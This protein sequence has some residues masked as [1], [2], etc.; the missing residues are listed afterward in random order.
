[1]TEQT[2]VCSL[3]VVQGAYLLA[4]ESKSSKHCSLSHGWIILTEVGGDEHLL[5]ASV[6]P[7]PIQTSV[8]PRDIPFPSG[9]SLLSDND[10]KGHMTEKGNLKAIW[11]T[12]CVCV[13]LLR[14]GLGFTDDEYR[15][16][17]QRNSQKQEHL[18]LHGGRK[19]PR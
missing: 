4:P 6:V 8:P 18:R 1:V 7:T 11:A 16:I 19:I 5:S 15:E 14:G 10:S 3:P 2:V 12:L 17:W 13:L 9:A